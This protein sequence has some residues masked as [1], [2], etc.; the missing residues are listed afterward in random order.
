MTIGNRIR[1]LRVDNNLLQSEL[2][3][4]IDVD[5]TAISRIENDRQE[6]QLNQLIKLCEHF[7]ID[8]KYLLRL[9]NKCRLYKEPD[10]LA[11]KLEEMIRHTIDAHFDIYR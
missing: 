10:I 1:G 8:P 7:R 9:S 4:I 5:R 2:A 6:L 3:N 11:R